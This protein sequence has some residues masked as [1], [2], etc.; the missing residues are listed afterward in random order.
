L[1]CLGLLLLAGSF[2]LA[3]RA[4]EAPLVPGR[5]GQTQL[6]EELRIGTLDGPDETLFGHITHLVAGHDGSIFVADRQLEILRAYDGEGNFLHAIGRKGEGP[7]EYLEILGMTVLPDG[8]LAIYDARNQRITVFR[9]DGSVLRDHPI[10]NGFFTSDPDMLRHDPDGN[11]TLRSSDPARTEPGKIHEVLLKISPQGEILERID[12]PE[13]GQDGMVLM[14]PEGPQRSFVPETLWTW[15][16]AG[17]LVIGSNEDYHL[18]LHFPGA[19]VRSIRRANEPVLLQPEEKEQWEA[20]A[21]YF[22]KRGLETGRREPK[23]SVPSRKPV[24][25]ALAA[26]DDGRIWVRRYVEA[27]PWDVS[28]REPGD[29][30]PL[31][32]WREP[33][34]YDV[35]EPDGTF[36][37]S[38]SIPRRTRILFRRGMQLWGVFTGDQGEQVVRFRI[39]PR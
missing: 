31:F 1:A 34:V 2:P 23:F 10:S 39:D 36:L 35:F 15:S 25:K 7:G 38:V 17:T 33:T 9:P 5:W 32:A 26:G 28:P 6:V 8:N 22:H 16:P 19:E 24:F 4:A 21:D 30:R 20:W 37:G 3:S 18:E 11:L 29:E 13:S 12:L 14:T 27:L